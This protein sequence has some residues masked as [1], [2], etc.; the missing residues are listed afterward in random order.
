MRSMSLASAAGLRSTNSVHL[1]INVLTQSIFSHSVMP[2]PEH[3]SSASDRKRLG[4]PRSF[5]KLRTH[6]GKY[7]SHPPEDWRTPAASR[8]LRLEEML[9]RLTGMCTQGFGDRFQF[10]L[11]GE[12]S[13]QG[14]DSSCLVFRPSPSH[15]L[16]TTPP[17]PVKTF[18]KL[19]L[20]LPVSPYILYIMSQSD[21][22]T[23]QTLSFSIR[24]R[25]HISLLL[26]YFG[27]LAGT[28]AATAK[29][30][31]MDLSSAGHPAVLAPNVPSF[32]TIAKDVLSK[33][34]TS[35]MEERDTQ[36]ARGFRRDMEENTNPSDRGLERSKSEMDIERGRGF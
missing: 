25:V 10:G 24:M 8:S 22:E 11:A 26:V 16:I 18:L 27:L 33:R 7:L 14:P 2:R 21:K 34:D 4:A 19:V 20:S 32:N 30:G 3:H 35:E 6:I 9:C 15:I 12:R 1:C 13:S 23:I 17:P 29:G 36:R 5:R 28:C 31:S